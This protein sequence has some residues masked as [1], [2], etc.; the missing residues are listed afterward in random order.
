MTYCWRHSFPPLPPPP[1]FAAANHSSSSLLLKAA[2]DK[3]GRW[4]QKREE[5]RKRTRVSLLSK[6]RARTD[7]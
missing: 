2:C 7:N 6:N 1:L 4:L 5:S 3:E